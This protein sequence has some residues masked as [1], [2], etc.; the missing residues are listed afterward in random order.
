MKVFVF[1]AVGMREYPTFSQFVK[2]TEPAMLDRCIVIYGIPRFHQARAMMRKYNSTSYGNA[3]FLLRKWLVNLFP[4]FQTR[5]EFQHASY[6]QE[7]G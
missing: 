5:K 3:R 2:E 4:S 1:G 7:R 6:I